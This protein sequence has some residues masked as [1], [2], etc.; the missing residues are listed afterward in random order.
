MKSSLPERRFAET[1][2]IFADVTGQAIGA[3]IGAGQHW[4]FS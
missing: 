4:K 1:T 2:I 3:A